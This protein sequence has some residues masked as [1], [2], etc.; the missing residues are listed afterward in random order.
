M[1]KYLALTLS[2]VLILSLTACANDPVQPTTLPRQT[3]ETT[4]K[5]TEEAATVATTEAAT[6]ATTPNT[7][8]VEFTTEPSDPAVIT[9]EIFLEGETEEVVMELHDGGNYIIYIPQGE[10]ILESGVEDGYFMDVWENVNN[11]N[12]QVSV[13][14][15]GAMTPEEAIAVIS[16]EESD[17]FFEETDPGV[18]R[19]MDVEDH[20]IMDVEVRTDGQ[21]TFALV[22]EYYIEA[23]EGF[24]VR[25]RGIMDTF[26]IK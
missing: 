12:L 20:T 7:E 10:W 4:E 9:T 19:G 22:T 14:Q 8:T 13:I 3:Q 21:Q 1:K 24:G 25:I 17:Y 11:E 18:Y 6:E 2:A 26:K 15:L 23:A 16:Q 5:P